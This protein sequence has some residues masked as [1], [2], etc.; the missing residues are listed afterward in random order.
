MAFVN[1]IKNGLVA[2]LLYCKENY[3]GF[4]QLSYLT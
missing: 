3:G 2:K 1:V 4:L